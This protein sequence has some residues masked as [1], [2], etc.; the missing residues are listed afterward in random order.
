MKRLLPWLPLAAGACLLACVPRA[1]RVA[2]EL[3]GRYDIGT[4]PAPAWQ[5]MEAGG[6][7]YALWNPSLHATIYTDSN[8]GP[9]FADTRLSSLATHLLHGL[10]DV[11]TLTEETLELAHRSALRVVRR[12]TLDGVPV[13]VGAVV[14]K[15]DTCNYDFV[16][17]APPDTFHRGVDA[18]QAVLDGFRPWEDD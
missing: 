5:P 7:D 11:Q 10:R 9:R 2:R 14:L 4:P 6:A 18:W 13:Q 12:G 16:Y 1:I 3:E 17:I 15:H 8:C